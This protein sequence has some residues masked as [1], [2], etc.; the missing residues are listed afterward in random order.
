MIR[1]LTVCVALVLSES[2]VAQNKDM[3]KIVEYTEASKP[4]TKPKE[5][6]LF[7][8]Y[9]NHISDQILNDCIYE[10]SCSRFSRGAFKHHGF[11]KGLFLTGDRLMRCNRASAVE[12]P[13]TRISRSGKILDHWTDYSFRE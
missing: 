10:H 4:V 1:I 3:E 5:K 11:F 8:F 12:V 9:Q 13:P 6:G 2:L 7:G